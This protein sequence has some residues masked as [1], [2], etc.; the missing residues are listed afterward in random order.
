MPLYPIALRYQNPL[1]W[2]VS[3]FSDSHISLYNNFK[4]LTI[5]YSANYV[6]FVSSKKIIADY[7]IF[8]GGDFY[9]KTSFHRSAFDVPRSPFPV[10]FNLKIKGS[11][12]MIHPGT[13]NGEGCTRNGER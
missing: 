5:E 8:K 9:H 1:K 6:F 13:R 11:E 12:M 2:A 3:N 4:T 10:P 7:S